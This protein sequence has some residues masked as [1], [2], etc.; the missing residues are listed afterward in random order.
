MTVFVKTGKL[1]LWFP[2]P[3]VFLRLVTLFPDDFISEVGLGS[4]ETAFAL[5]RA[6]KQAHRDFPGLE[7]VHVLSAD[8]EEVI[9]KL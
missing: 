4:R 5:Y 9:V 6:L 1:R 7:L 8:G 3:L 2:V